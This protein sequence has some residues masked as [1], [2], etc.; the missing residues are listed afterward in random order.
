MQKLRKTYVA[1]TYFGGRW[2]LPLG[3]IYQMA[4]MGRWAL[5]RKIGLPENTTT[6]MYKIA[7]IVIDCIPYVLGGI[8]IFIL[9]FSFSDIKKDLMK[10]GIWK[11]GKSEEYQ[12]QKPRAELWAEVHGL[13]SE[14]EKAD[15]GDSEASRNENDK[16]TTS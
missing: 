7:S 9:V 4:N 13:I 11:S 1:F 6:W 14:L 5:L 3:L 16:T 10:L 15:R 2:I 12:A 8:G